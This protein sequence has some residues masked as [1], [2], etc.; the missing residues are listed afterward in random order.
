[1]LF[2]SAVSAKELST[3]EA[4]ALYKYRDVGNSISIVRY[5]GS[6]ITIPDKINGKKVTKILES[7][8]KGITSLKKVVFGSNITDVGM[9]A[10]YNCSNLETLVLNQGISVL[11]DDAFTKT[12]LISVDFPDT[13]QRIGFM[14]FSG[15]TKLTTFRF[16][17]NAPQ[18]VQKSFGEVLSTSLQQLK[19]LKLVKRQAKPASFAEGTVCDESAAGTERQ[20]R[21]K[22]TLPMW[23]WEKVQKVLRWLNGIDLEIDD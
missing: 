13:L 2:S 17:G 3:S 11:D 10:F 12:G 8:F 4:N 18:I 7:A 16:A 22:R 5:M 6:E 19:L 1:M 23:Q 14:C 9:F 21:E 20:G 15:D